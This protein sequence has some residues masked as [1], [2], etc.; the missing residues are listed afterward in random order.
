MGGQRHERD[1]L[2]E[3]LANFGSGIRSR[4]EVAWGTSGISANAEVRTHSSLYIGSA[5]VVVEYA[6]AIPTKSLKRYRRIKIKLL[7][8]HRNLLTKVLRILKRNQ[9]TVEILSIEA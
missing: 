2:W 5:D 7:V 4:W 9:F 3:Q 6:K 8:K 1:D